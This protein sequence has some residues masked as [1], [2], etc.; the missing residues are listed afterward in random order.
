[1][2][3]QG[4]DGVPAVLFGASVLVSV[5]VSVFLVSLLELDESDALLLLEPLEPPELALLDP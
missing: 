3:T 2:L 5:L 1:M 4:V